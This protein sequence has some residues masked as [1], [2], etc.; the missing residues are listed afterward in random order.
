MKQN[1]WKLKCSNY[2]NGESKVEYEVDRWRCPKVY[3]NRRG[4][5]G[6]LF[7][8]I[9]IFTHQNY[10]FVQSL[11]VVMLVDGRKVWWHLVGSV[12][13]FIPQFHLFPAC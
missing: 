2:Q 5:V 12:M 10:I 4:R 13:V 6:V 7:P 9:I 8:L 11:C 1:R 3:F